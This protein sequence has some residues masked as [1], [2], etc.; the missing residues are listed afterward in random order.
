MR[1]RLLTALCLLLACGAVSSAE[2]EWDEAP[3]VYTINP[4]G[5]VLASDG[6]R[7]TPDHY[8]LTN[9]AYRD[10]IFEF[11]IRQAAP[12]GARARTI[13]CWGVDPA[14][15]GN[16]KSYF[17]AGRGI[18]QDAWMHVRL[19]VLGENVAL[20]MDGSRI[21][22]N[23]TLY[24]AP[25]EEGRVGLLHYY[26]YNYEFRNLSIVPLTAEAIPAPA[27]PKIAFD[28]M[29]VLTLSWSTPDEY[30]DVLNHR[31]Y[32]AEGHDVAQDDAFLLGTVR[33]TEYLDAGVKSN[34]AYSYLVVR[35]LGEDTPGKPTAPIAVHT[36]TLPPPPA[37]SWARAIRRID[38][39]IRVRWEPGLGGRLRGYQVSRGNTGQEARGARPFA[40]LLPPDTDHVLIPGTGDAYYAVA[41]VDP[42][43][44][45][46]PAAV[47]R[48]EAHAPEVVAGGGIPEGHPYLQYSREQIDH[49][50]AAMA[51]GEDAGGIADG[52]R[53][54]TDSATKSP[55]P[56][57]TEP[58]DDRGTLPNRL[59]Q[60]AFA[61]QLL[62]DV[63]YAEYVRDAMVRLAEIYPT[64]EVRGG[65]VRMAKTASGLYEAVWYVPIV[66]AYD[67]TCDSP[68]YSAEDRAKIERDFL[69]LA[70]DLF[71][72][73]DYADRSDPRARDLHYKCYNFQAWFISALG[74]TGLVLRDADMIE[75]AIDGPYGLK[76][77]LAHDVHDDGIFWERS[78]GYHHFVISALFP[79]LQGGYHCN[80]DLWKLAVPDDYNE[81]REPLG[82]Y[83]V[84]DGDNGPKSMRLMFEGPFYSTFPDLT[85]PVIGDSSQ[86]PL[87]AGE[88]YRAAWEHYRT[89]E[90]AWLVNRSL[91]GP[92]KAAV[93][94]A[95]DAGAQVR[96]AWDDEYLYIGADIRDQLVR[97]S[98]TEPGQVWA[99]DALWV[100]LKWLDEPVLSYDFIYGFSPGDFSEVKPVPALFT[101]FAAARNEN[102]SARYAVEKTKHGYIVEAG[103]PWSEFV[104]ADAEQGTALKPSDGL[105]LTADFVIYDCDAAAGATTKEKMVGWSRQ[106]DRYDPSHGGR[107]VFSAEQPEARYAINAPRAEAIAVDGDLG[108]WAHLPAKV[109]VIDE[110]SAVT[111]DSGAASSRAHD[112]LYTPPDNPGEFTLT[113]DSFANNG[114]LR[115]GCSLFPSTGWALLRDHL[116]SSGWP[117]MDA[118]SV[119]L[120]YGPYGG[121]HGHPD[122]LSIVAFAA[123]RQIIP[124]FGSCGYSSAEKGQWT[125]HTVSHNTITVDGISQYPAG[126]VDKTWPIDTS[127][128]QAIGSLELFYADPGLKLARAS[129]DTVFEGVR[130]TRTV[131]L[132]G[133]TLLDFHR[134]E[135]DQEHR[136]DY[137]LHI[138]GS[139]Q[140]GENALDPATLSDLPDPLGER[141]GYQHIH[142]AKTTGPSEAGLLTLWGRNDPEIRISTCPGD[143]P[144][145]LIAAESITT[146]LDRLMP[147]MILRRTAQ[148][149]TFA[150]A[151]APASLPAARWQRNETGLWVSHGDGRL[152]ISEDPDEWSEPDDGPRFRGVMFAVNRLGDAAVFSFVGMSEL[153]F[154]G[155]LRIQADRPISFH[156]TGAA[157]AAAS[158]LT[159]APDSSGRLELGIGELDPIIIDAQ[160]G[161]SYEIP[162]SL[163]KYAGLRHPSRL[164]VGDENLSTDRR[165]G[166][167]VMIR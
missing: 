83:T 140:A 41:A 157:G 124:D 52:L 100:G 14:D 91:P 114:T 149:T 44:K 55:A 150:T 93:S 119:N 159:M 136:Y 69:R 57:P 47:C 147:M 163:E 23:P 70:A 94:G 162:E 56:V 46:G 128:K 18:T 33:G 79:F 95:D 28:D 98:H 121:G 12:I 99:G 25:L 3:A 165:E 60:V 53:R 122:T 86:G 164:T 27:E 63:R 134:V 142:N 146:A 22:G 105:E 58:T 120:N 106:T 72:V 2:I 115:E 167:T 13:V 31:I 75:H 59:R 71:W 156:I 145:E 154:P 32:R 65:R 158:T 80:M 133:N 37:P 24:E 103:I 35:I 50:R 161:E 127:S 96:V 42:E 143:A 110:N 102:S 138:D 139:L 137:V 77:L 101:R 108:D 153:D 5:S 16:R 49:A 1:T 73:K 11:D 45:A 26:N 10:F 81:D 4:D 62:D 144:T 125:A 34:T 104:P 113:G 155:A 107:L 85:W 97:N 152:F 74:L 131:A 111:T 148:S 19:V 76:H 21:A 84:G 78:L 67:M 117:P 123:G 66:L 166:N 7:S 112:L 20:F 87:R 88:P 6:G 68:A 82:N 130:L 126:T 48:A 61:Y 89:P 39:M 40:Q 29:G 92:T 43:G 9:Q 141:C 118:V 15:H 38:D 132:A 17:L 135:S 30:A 36:G 151:I 54:Q 8:L 160:A 64:L 90:L 109:A 116:D 51:H 129:C